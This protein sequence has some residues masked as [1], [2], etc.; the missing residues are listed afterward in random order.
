LETALELHD[1]PRVG[2]VDEWLG[3]DVAL[4]FSHPAAVWALPIETISQ[5]EGGYEAVFQSTALVPHW[6]FTAPES[7]SVHLRISL[8]VDTSAAQAR[9]LLEIPVPA[10]A[11]TNQG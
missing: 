11:V 7:G 2:V 10:L 5:S 3:L 8:V 1:M 4:E 6:E 9:K